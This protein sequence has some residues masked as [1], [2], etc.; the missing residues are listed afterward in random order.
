MSEY[1]E[2]EEV[3]NGVDPITND[4]PT[5]DTSD[6][7]RT[8]GACVQTTMIRI[9]LN[10]LKMKADVFSDEQADFRVRWN[11]VEPNIQLK[12]HHYKTPR[13]PAHRL[14]QL[15]LRQEGLR[16]SLALYVLW[17]DRGGFNIVEGLVQ[18]IHALCEQSS[19]SVLQNS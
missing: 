8:I 15:H 6:I 9:I 1:L 10:R 19:S 2:T 7:A 17:K 12:S 16:Q 5:K 18:V 13:A 3:A 14:P 4:T 11:R